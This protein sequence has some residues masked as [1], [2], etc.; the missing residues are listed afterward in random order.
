MHQYIT[1]MKKLLLI[2]FFVALCCSATRPIERGKYA[3]NDVV[4]ETAIEDFLRCKSS[5]DHNVFSILINF[6]S[7][8]SPYKIEDDI[9]TLSILPKETTDPQYYITLVDT[10]GSTR[11]PTRHV[12]KDGKL[13]YWHDP[14][15]GL[16][17]ETIEAFLE[18]NLAER[19]EISDLSFLLG[20]EVYGDE[21]TK[22]AQ[23]Y[24][25]KNDLTN[26]KRVITNIAIGWYK[27]PRLKC[28]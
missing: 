23:Y 24:F 12:I 26:Y 4:I 22:A 5:K 17:K 19:L 11:L 14:D 1:D 6:H 21:R 10:L 27:P 16:T 7:E 15:Y 3:T 28:R 25:C 9:V 20:Q 8:H 18:F 13:F 2:I